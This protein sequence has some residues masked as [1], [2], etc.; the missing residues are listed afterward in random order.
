MEAA[1]TCAGLDASHESALARARMDLPGQGP[2]LVCN[3]LSAL[4]IHF[5]CDPALLQADVPFPLHLR[6]G[7][8]YVSLV[9]FTIHRL[10]PM[11]LSPARLKDS[12]RGIRPAVGAYSSDA[13]ATLDSIG[14][15]L[16]ELAFWPVGTHGFLNVRTYVEY[17]GEPGIHFIVEW[18]PN[19]LSVLLGPWMYGLPYNFGSLDYDHDEK[20]NDLRGRVRGANGLELSYSGAMKSPLHPS[21]AG[22]LPHFLLERYTAFTSRGKTKRLFRVWHEPWQ[23]ADVDIT[24]HDTALLRSR[25]RWFDSARLIGANFSPGVKDVWMSAPRKL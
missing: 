8:A 7:R 11:L 4:F 18:L 22:T 14:G 3:W 16:G 9:A 1:A 10:R 2:A 5:E 24:L 23:Q 15:R 21:V 12:D 13:I 6:H 25:C 20:R 19:R 17:N